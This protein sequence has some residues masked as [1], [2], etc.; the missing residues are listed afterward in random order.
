MKKSWLFV[1]IFVFLFSGTALAAEDKPTLKQ[2]NIKVSF[3]QDGVEV[4]EQ[5]TLANVETIKEG[6]IEHIFTKFENAKVEDLVIKAGEQ[7]L[8]SETQ[9]GNVLERILVSVP[10]G[11]TG[12]FSYTVD[13]R[14][15]VNGEVKQVP[16]VVP[17]VPPDGAGND[18]SLTVTIPKGQYLQDSFPIIDSGKTG[19]LKENMMNVP[20]FLKLQ[21]GSSPAGFFTATNFYTL[22]GLIVILGFI[23]A[24][25]IS[26]RKAKTGGLANV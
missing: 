23:G 7:E 6:E 26:E 21:L 22:F 10:Q 11:T 24:W 12:D 15:S 19:T 1:L 17:A 2:A 18:V 16:L 3:G 14:L 9:E 8:S 4:V 25:L 13:F 20:N 5:I